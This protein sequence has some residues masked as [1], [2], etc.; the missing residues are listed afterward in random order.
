MIVHGGFE[1][2]LI[3]AKAL[4]TQCVFGQ[5][6]WETIG[7]IELERCIACQNAA[8]GHARS[9]FVQQ[10]DTLVEGATELR[11]FLLQ[12]RFNQW[13]CTQQFRVSRPHLGG[14]AADQTVHQRLLRAKNMR[15]PH[16]A[17]H[18]TTQD[19]TATFVGWHHAV[20]QKEAGR[21]QMVGNYAV[22]CLLFANRL[23]AGKLFGSVDERLEGIR[24]VIVGN[25][26]HNR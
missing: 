9:R 8:R 13:L 1:T 15:V 22:A 26:L 25:A 2:S 5:I 10:L 16:C 14:E 23:G 19:I 21:A 24:V 6:I 17:T 11:F 4:R 12:C 7:I 18:D 3:D 20:R